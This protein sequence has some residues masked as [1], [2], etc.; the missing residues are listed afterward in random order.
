VNAETA[1]LSY[2]AEMLALVQLLIAEAQAGAGR[3]AQH[4]DDGQADPGPSD[5]PQGQHGAPKTSGIQASG[6]R[7]AVKL[8][9]H[10]GMP[11]LK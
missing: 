7:C 8:V 11:A 9:L 10:T 2:H 4:G 5:A 1:L 3:D 6:Y